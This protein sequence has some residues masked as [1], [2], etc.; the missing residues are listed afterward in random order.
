[1]GVFLP[2]DISQRITQFMNGKSNF[3]FIKKEEIIGVFYLFG[4]D[5]GI[6]GQTELLI[7][8]DL[9]KRTI[10]QLS[11]DV[12]T[13]HT[14]VNKMDSKSIRENYMRRALQISVEL[15]NNNINN[16]SSSSS[17]I[18]PKMNKRI[19]GD[20]TILSSCFAQ[21]IAHYK[22]DYFFELFQP[23]KETQVPTSL[24]SKL[25]N[26]MLLLGFNVKNLK[27]LPFESSFS[28]FINWLKNSCQ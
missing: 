3:P 25:E 10:A 22:Q 4:K 5:Y 21:H 18:E 26:R 23:F 20:P 15:R 2:E 24:R 27:S 17:S 11:R 13:F 1:M 6:T 16:P 19:S 28:P 9:A 12:R 14:M 8:T 7:T